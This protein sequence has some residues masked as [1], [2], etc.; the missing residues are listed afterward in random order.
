MA[1][2][3]PKM[4]IVRSRP[5]LNACRLLACQCC[6]INDGT[7]VAAHSNAL[8]HGKGKA[9]KAS[10]VKVAALCWACHL[11][12]DQGSRLSRQQRRDLWWKAHVKTV[13][14]L[15]ESGLWPASVAVPD[16]MNSP[17]SAPD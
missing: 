1:F 6:G 5:L 4:A 17:F 14:L 16:I 15:V 12:I 9:M 2:A 11:C 7:V 3:V 10:D 13:R 8:Q